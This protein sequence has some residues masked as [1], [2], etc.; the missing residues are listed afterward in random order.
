MPDWPFPEDSSIERARRV[1]IAYRIA[2]LEAAPEQCAIL[3]TQMRY[4]NQAWVL[5][6]QDAWDDDDLISGRVAAELLSVTPGA[7]RQYR[8]RGL[9][10]GYHTADGWQYRVADV[11]AFRLSPPGRKRS[12]VLAQ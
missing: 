2:L 3:D 1:A 4:F 11:R 9:L 10:L 12:T 6:Q 7:V 5:G 8:L